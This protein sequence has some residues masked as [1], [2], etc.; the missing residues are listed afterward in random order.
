[1]VYGAGGA[2]GVSLSESSFLRGERSMWEAVFNLARISG[3]RVG[4]G[5]KLDFLPEQN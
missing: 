5:S 1:M 3:S 2:G 4:D